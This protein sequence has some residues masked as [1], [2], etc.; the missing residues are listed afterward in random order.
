MVVY[1]S[2]VTHNR[3]LAG[4]HEDGRERDFRWTTTDAEGRFEFPAHVVAEALK[5]Y[6]DFDPR[7]A[8]LLLHREYGRPLVSVPKD[9][10]QRESIVWEVEPE[11]MSLERMRDETDCDLVCDLGWP[12][13]AHCYEYSCGRPFP[14][15]RKPPEAR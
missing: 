12:A 1:Q 5:N 10:S 11:R 13:F 6:V 4:T 15:S 2:Y 14:D 3:M 8:I 9:P 7:P